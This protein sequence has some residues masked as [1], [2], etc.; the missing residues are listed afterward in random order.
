MNESVIL[1]DLILT[2]L[3][4]NKK[5]I[6]FSYGDIYQN[7]TNF[8]I[9]IILKEIFKEKPEYFLS[10]FNIK[11]SFLSLL[12]CVRNIFNQSIGYL[13]YNNYVKERG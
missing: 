5:L 4:K 12:I 2:K 13:C 3:P 8:S 9:P 11:N 6:V 7:E 10:F 1:Q